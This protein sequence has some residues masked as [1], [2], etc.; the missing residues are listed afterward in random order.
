MFGS[1]LKKQ[2]L[3]YGLL[4]KNNHGRETYTIIKIFKPSEKSV[5]ELPDGEFKLDTWI[6]GKNFRFKIMANDSEDFENVIFSL[7][8]YES[9]AKSNL[10]LLGIE[11]SKQSNSS[12][13][14]LKAVGRV[15]EKLV[16]FLNTINQE[17]RLSETSRKKMLKPPKQLLSLMN[18][19]QQ[20][21]LL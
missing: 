18:S 3:K 19:Y 11:T 14:T 21:S 15:P 10:K 9:I 8:S 12:L 7:K 5:L 4:Q 17:L 20:F 13:I 6:S 2:N 16:D 1:R